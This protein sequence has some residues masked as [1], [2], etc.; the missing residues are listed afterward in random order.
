MHVHASVMHMHIVLPVFHKAAY[1]KKIIKVRY[2]LY[3]PMVIRCDRHPFNP[4][5]VDWLAKRLRPLPREGLCEVT[6]AQLWVQADERET[7]RR[8]LA[9][10]GQPGESPT[11]RDLRDWM[12]EEEPFL[13]NGTCTRISPHGLT[14][15]HRPAGPARLRGIPGL[16]GILWYLSLRTPVAGATLVP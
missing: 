12:A 13:T 6:G 14:S 11:V 7:E 16:A 8:S 3:V 1:G 10:V 4:F 9:R 15:A 2:V 5:E